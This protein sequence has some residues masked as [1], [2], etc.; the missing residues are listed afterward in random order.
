MD[1][2]KDLQN[3][4]DEIEKLSSAEHI[5][6]LRI[7]KNAKINLSENSNGCFVDMNLM[8]EATIQSIRK[9][10]DFF[11][12]KETELNEQEKQKNSLIDSLN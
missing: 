1:K 12:Q 8:D 7:L 10:I 5:E 9:Y 3:L 6:I 11:N 4:C 2:Y